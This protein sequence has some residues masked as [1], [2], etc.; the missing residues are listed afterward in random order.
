MS[1]KYPRREI[2]SLIMH[3]EPEYEVKLTM[4]THK[5]QA[6]TLL[7]AVNSIWSISANKMH[8]IDNQLFQHL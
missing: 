1:K 8:C 6:I 2:I 5:F 7:H 4:F 3:I